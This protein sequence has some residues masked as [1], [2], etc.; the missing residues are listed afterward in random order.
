VNDLRRLG[1]WTPNVKPVE[2]TLLPSWIDSFHSCRFERCCCSS[3]HIMIRLVQ[4]M[5]SLIATKVFY[6]NNANANK[7]LPNLSSLAPFPAPNRFPR[8]GSFLGSIPL[9]HKNLHS[10]VQVVA[11]VLF[12]ITTTRNTLWTVTLGAFSP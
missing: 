6:I 9:L 1:F 8:N 4:R 7:V 5:S 2:D 10:V 11:L 3:S 12:F